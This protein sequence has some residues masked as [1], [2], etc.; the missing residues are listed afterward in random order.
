MKS[1]FQRQEQET[2]QETEIAQ[3]NEWI[4]GSEDGLTDH[5]LMDGE[6]ESDSV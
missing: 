2:L 5:E 3:I 1:C 6:K 4:Y